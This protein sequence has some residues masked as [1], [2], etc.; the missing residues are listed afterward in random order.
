MGEFW[1]GL[2]FRRRRR[3]IG[4]GWRKRRARGGC[5]YRRRWAG[6]C[7]LLGAEEVGVDSI[8]E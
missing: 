6:Q 4:S 7:L 2:G 5:R 1:V 3:E 8:A